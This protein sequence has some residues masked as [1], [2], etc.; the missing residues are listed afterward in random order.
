[1]WSPEQ[2]KLGG[3]EESAAKYEVGGGSVGQASA[4]LGPRRG[5]RVYLSSVLRNGKPTNGNIFFKKI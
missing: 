1:M 5:L 2:R 3:G 4:S